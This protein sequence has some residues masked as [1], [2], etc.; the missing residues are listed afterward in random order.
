MN[1]VQS[2]WPGFESAL[3]LCP[4]LVLLL[5]IALAASLVEVLRPRHRRGEVPRSAL[6]TNAGFSVA[7]A[8]L[9]VCGTLGST[10]LVM[11]C[12]RYLFPALG[13]LYVILG[14]VVFARMP[15]ALA[16]IALASI[17]CVNLANRR[18]SLLP[19]LD[20]GPLAD[21]LQFEKCLERSHEYRE[22]HDSNVRLARWLEQHARAELLVTMHPF[23]HFLGLPRLGYVRQPLRGYCLALGRGVVPGFQPLTDLHSNQAIDPLFVRERFEGRLV[24][25]PPCEPGDEVIHD[26]RLTP[27]LLAFKKR[28]RDSPPR[29]PAQLARWY[30]LQGWPG[31]T[32]AEQVSGRLF[33]LSYA[34]RARDAVRE[35]QVAARTQPADATL[36]RLGA[37]LSANAGD[38]SESIALA[39]RW[40]ALEPKSPAACQMLAQLRLQGGDSA[41]AVDLLTRARSAGADSAAVFALLGLAHEQQGNWSEA[42]EAYSQALARTSESREQAR[43]TAALERCRR[44][45]GVP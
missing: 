26:D 45:T 38:L 6:P 30:A 18:G 43:V 1:D 22:F 35:A 29:Q 34:G 40:L 5:A 2:R 9:F 12:P 27:P 32:L 39:E 20:S 36:L 19:P 7:L 37:E 33:C 14:C 24:T 3:Y 8:W 44:R 16:V 28:W 41:G 11:F 15:R 25:F 10:A 13:F 4:D 21:K 17:V 23:A 42:L 31:A